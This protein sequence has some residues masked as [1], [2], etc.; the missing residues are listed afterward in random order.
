MTLANIS[1]AKAHLSALL[2]K[3]QRGEEVI[4][5]K[6]GKP[7]AKLVPF[8][9][10]DRKREPDILK[11]KLSIGEDFDEPLPDH[12]VKKFEGH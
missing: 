7:I 11:G 12:I 8:N 6:A 9:R 10:S 2:E 4:I 1:D 3:V 5:S